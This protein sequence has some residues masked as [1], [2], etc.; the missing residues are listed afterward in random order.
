LDLQ[1]GFVL[2]SRFVSRE[3]LVIAE[4]SGD[5]NILIL[6]SLQSMVLTSNKAL[7][8]FSFSN[9]AGNRMTKELS[10]L[11]WSNFHRAVLFNLTKRYKPV[12]TH[13]AVVKI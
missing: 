9:A 8:F 3:L 5:I 4:A 12:F 2:L 7:M 1:A 6:R 11:R 13:L 10:G